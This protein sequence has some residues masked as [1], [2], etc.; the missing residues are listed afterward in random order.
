MKGRRG[1]EAGE[2]QG[3]EFGVVSPRARRAADLFFADLMGAPVKRA[4]RRAGP[5]P[6]W[7]PADAAEPEQA[8]EGAGGDG[9]GGGAAGHEAADDESAV[10]GGAPHEIWEVVAFP[11]SATPLGELRRGDLAISHAPDA[12]R[13]AQLRIVGEDVPP[14]ALYG[15]DGRFRRD[16][17]ALRRRARWRRDAGYEAPNDDQPDALQRS[18]A[19]PVSSDDDE[20]APKATSLA[21]V[22]LGAT[23]FS[24]SVGSA[25][26]ERR[27]SLEE[28]LRLVLG[29]GGRCFALCGPLYGPGETRILEFTPPAA[30]A[31]PLPLV[32]DCAALVPDLSALVIS[33]GNDAAAYVPSTRGN[34]GIPAVSAAVRRWVMIPKLRE[35]YRLPVDM[36]KKLRAPWMKALGQVPN[37]GFKSGALDALPVPALRLLLAQNAAAALPVQRRGPTGYF[38]EGVTLVLPA[39]PLVEPD[40]YMQVT[41]QVEGN[42]E[43]V[44]AWDTSAGISVGPIQN[45]LIPTFWGT[46]QTLFPILWRLWLE[47]RA[48]F[49]QEFSALGWRMRSEPP[50]HPKGS[51]TLVLTVGATGG[52]S[53]DLRGVDGPDLDRNI[54]Y[55]QT[56][57]AGK[58]GFD[59][60]FRQ[61][62]AGRFRNVIAWPHVQQI[63]LDVASPWLQP[64]LAIMN[65]KGIPALD[66]NSPDRD[67]FTL[68]ALLMSTFVRNSP[69]LAQLID[70]LGDWKRTD[71]KIEHITDAIAK[72]TNL[73]KN[74]KDE[75]SD[76]MRKQLPFARDI[77]NDL[78]QLRRTRTGAGM[79]GS[80]PRAEEL[81]ETFVEA[82]DRTPGEA[83]DVAAAEIAAEAFEGEAFGEALPEALPRAAAPQILDFTDGDTLDRAAPGAL[84]SKAADLM[85]K[86]DDLGIGD[87]PKGRRDAYLDALAWGEKPAVRAGL[88]S[89]SPGNPTLLSGLVVRSLWRLLGARDGAQIDPPFRADTLITDLQK[90]AAQSK[91]L[92][93][94]R[95]RADLDRVDPQKGD[96]I[97]LGTATALPPGT[98]QH[99]FTIVER[100]GDQF[101]SVDGG[102]GGKLGVGDGATDDGPCCGIHRRVR[103]LKRGDIVFVE[104]KQQRPITAVV[105][106]ERLSLTAPLFGVYRK[107][108]PRPGIL[109]SFQEDL[110]PREGEDWHEGWEAGGEPGAGEGCRVEAVESAVDAGEA[111]PTDDDVVRAL[112]RLGGT[113]FGNFAG[114]RAALVDGTVFG[115]AV[116]GLHPEFLRKLQ[117]AEAA[118]AAA[119]GGSGTP[120]WRIASAGGFRRA[121]GRHN[122][123]LAVDLNYASSPYIMHERGEVALDAQLAPV[124]E[125]IAL[126]VLGRKSV[127]PR[128]ITQGSKSAARTTRLYRGLAEESAAMIQ[129]FACLDEIAQVKARLVTRP[130]TVDGARAFFGDDTAATPENVRR[131]IMRDYVILTGRAGPAVAGESYPTVEAVPHADRPF[132]GDSAQ[133]DPRRGFLSI[134]QEI[135][136][137]LSAQGLRW[138]AIDF[139]GESGDVMHF[140][141]GN[142]ALDARIQQARAAAAGG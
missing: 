105:K 116:Q 95:T 113:S 8:F 98:A 141:D 69:A 53:V 120:A 131:R 77:F 5:P 125:R 96:A 14:G 30:P 28:A 91:A 15:R 78:D 35:F 41:S 36:Q 119:I 25:G 111:A 54:G 89:C 129:Y 16:T 59:P 58:A 123:G 48:L 70:A 109:E 97:F 49:D 127:I 140:D 20:A 130:L 88:R 44:N 71:Q 117:R 68:R 133:R 64:G 80:A 85:S 21:D 50:T 76:R 90:Y 7:A 115:C 72:L 6:G 99:V 10:L 32:I 56:G 62:L 73:D 26:E 23:S 17:L 66:L 9:L 112:D 138:G 34:P 135:V 136:E 42:L 19:W 63:I 33:V 87:N 103:T 29:R 124:Y 67:I 126:F 75:L 142:G 92:E 65:A 52:G 38:V 83:Y 39:Y 84:A 18:R 128:D 100:A 86:L 118:A 13:M 55:F 3:R 79:A 114:Y 137:A 60:P 108:P 74:T 40:C 106:L 94:I 24:I 27:G 57:V 11:G 110:E 43:S 61:D 31:G 1:Y 134:R 121:A 47:D 51:D 37:L 122:W 82:G 104:D 101:I 107:S 81:D 139:G 132:A 93:F 46:K 22:K 12:G 45:N 102:Q 4:R 2:G